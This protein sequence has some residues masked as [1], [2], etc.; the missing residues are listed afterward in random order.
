MKSK[1]LVFEDYS[2]SDCREIIGD[3]LYLINGGAQ[4]ENTNEAVGGGVYFEESICITAGAVA[5]FL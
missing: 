5:E 4:I 3:D 1:R 2:F